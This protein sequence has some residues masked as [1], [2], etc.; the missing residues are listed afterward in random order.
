MWNSIQFINSLA[1]LKK[2]I[3]ITTQ[4]INDQLHKAQE[5]IRWK[6]EIDWLIIIWCIWSE[7]RKPINYEIRLWPLPLRLGPEYAW[8]MMKRLKEK[9]V[10][11]ECLEP[12][13][14][15]DD[16]QNKIIST[17]IRTFCCV[18][19]IHFISISIL[20]VLYTR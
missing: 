15:H 11:G 17:K 10:A 12:S 16:K 18:N 8:A 5:D 9:E 2:M 14:H 13:T 3:S 7:L 19:N 6:N 4:L 1:P 20:L